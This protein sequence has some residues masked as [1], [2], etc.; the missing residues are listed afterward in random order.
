MR[1]SGELDRVGLTARGS[2]GRT[3]FERGDMTI[4]GRAERREGGKDYWEGGGEPEYNGNGGRG[5]GG[6]GWGQGSDWKG[7]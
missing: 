3:G 7:V 4:E 5:V 1:G 6:W 2:V